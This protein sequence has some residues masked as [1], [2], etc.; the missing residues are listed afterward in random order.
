MSEPT[1]V[2]A[3]INNYQKSDRTD[4]VA[5]PAFGPG[6]MENWG[7]IKYKE[8]LVLLREGIT[9]ESITTLVAHEVGHQVKLA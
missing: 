4:G 7:L 8:R 3:F 5:L 6:G 1:A 9:S 2:K